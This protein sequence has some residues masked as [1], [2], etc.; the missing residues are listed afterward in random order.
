LVQ[1]PDADQRRRQCRDRNSH[2]LSCHNRMSERCGERATK[3]GKD[4]VWSIDGALLLS[5]IVVIR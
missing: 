2:N 1:Q 4:F 3:S 5:R